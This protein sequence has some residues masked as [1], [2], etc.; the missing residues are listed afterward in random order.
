[1][2]ESSTERTATELIDEPAGADGT[3]GPGARAG[4]TAEVVPVSV[5][6]AEP[7]P[8]GC[9]GC[10]GTDPFRAGSA[11]VYAVGRIEPRFPTLGAEKEFTQVTGRSEVTG[12][13][14]REALQAVLA[15]PGNRYLARQLCW[16][17]TIQG[18]ETYLLY[19]RDPLDLSQLVEAVRPRPDPGDLDVVIGTAGPIAPPEACNGLAVPVV[20]FDQIYSFDR[21]TLLGSLP[22]PDG[23]DEDRY[24]STAEEVLD[25]VL[26][27]SDNAGAADEH[28]AVNYLA[29]RYPA[30]YA[31]AAEAF[32]RNQSL[33]AV[34]VRPSRMGGGGRTIV[35]V[36]FSYTGRDTDVTE[37]AFVR[38][39]VTERFPFLVTRLQPYFE[40]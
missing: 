16:V 28:R 14:D 9:P 7:T 33:A 40:R 21:R 29:V 39:D 34:E 26:Q 27:L 30:V 20:A 38:V 32:G 6:A 36:V 22:V 19:P 11:H 25:L 3:G 31:R 18:L 35:D 5:A 12:L 17:L 15:Q 1:M 8:A 37:K 13:T 10:G 2:E 4:E 23:Q 24:R